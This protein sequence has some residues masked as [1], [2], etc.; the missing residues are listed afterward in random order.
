MRES[1]AKRSLIA[2]KIETWC[3]RETKTLELFEFKEKSFQP[4]KNWFFACLS[5]CLLLFVGISIGQT[6]LGTNK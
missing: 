6:C 1:G 3:F 4:M 2:L 5:V